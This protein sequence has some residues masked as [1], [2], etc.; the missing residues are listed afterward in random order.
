MWNA[1]CPRSQSPFGKNRLPYTVALSLYQTVALC[2]SSDVKLPQEK[3]LTI[4]YSPF[5]IRYLLF[6]IRYS[7]FAIYYLL[8]AI[9]HSLF[10]LLLC[11]FTSLDVCQ[12]LK[13]VLTIKR[14]LK[15]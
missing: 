8:F 14:R 2:S 12:K 9:Y 11:L 15:L 3:P 10:A 7:P 13:K 6:A 1:P 5:A 4:C